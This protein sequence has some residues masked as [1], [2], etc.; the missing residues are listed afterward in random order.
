MSS[1]RILSQQVYGSS[2]SYLAHLQLTQ[3]RFALLLLSNIPH[4]CFAPFIS[5]IHSESGNTK[6]TVCSLP[7]GYFSFHEISVP[8][9]VL[10]KLLNIDDSIL[11]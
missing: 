9:C 5:T 10:I 1:C 3:I 11:W 6:L 2:R 4:N 7:L 8:F